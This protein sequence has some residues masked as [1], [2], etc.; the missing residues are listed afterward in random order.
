MSNALP[1]PS[2]RRSDV[3]L[4]PTPRQRRQWHRMDMRHRYREAGTLPP[5]GASGEPV[6][7][8]LRHTAW[9]PNGGSIVTHIAVHCA[10]CAVHTKPRTHRLPRGSAAVPHN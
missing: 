2:S 7:Q 6:R 3:Y 5:S 1:M 4:P 10:P 9:S 8:P